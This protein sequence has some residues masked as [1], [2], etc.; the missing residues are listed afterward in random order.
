MS[1]SHDPKVVLRARMRASL[2]A[3]TPE[4]REASSRAICERLAAFDRIVAAAMVMIYMPLRTEVDVLPFARRFLA[5]GGHLVVPRTDRAARTIE[6]AGVSSVERDEFE[7]DA[8]GVLR[9]RR[10]WPVSTDQVD[11][12]LVPGLAFDAAGRRIGRGGGFYDRFLLRLPPATLSVGVA[13]E[14]QRIDEVPADPHDRR[15]DVVV[16]ERRLTYTA[17]RPGEGAAG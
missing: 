16:T 3:M 5:A 10:W 12:I 4:A 6:P 1:T 2:A 17:A 7:V 13:F 11:V 9:P 14:A 15:V 8:M